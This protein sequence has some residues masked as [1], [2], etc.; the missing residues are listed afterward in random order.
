[1]SRSLPL[2]NSMQI[3]TITN[4]NA[5]IKSINFNREIP[6]EQQRYVTVFYD[7]HQK[8]PTFMLYSMF[9]YKNERFCNTYISFYH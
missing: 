2:I 6:K 9:I 7:K 3:Y 8:A 1:M 5:N 4:K